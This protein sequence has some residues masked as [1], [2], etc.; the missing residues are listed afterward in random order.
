MMSP[1]I[2]EIP[3]SRRVPRSGLLLMVAALCM[4]CGPKAGGP[5]TTVDAYANA[6]ARQDYATAYGFMSATFRD[7]H[8][9][10]EFVR[11]MKENAAEANET[12]ARLRSPNREMNVTAEFRFGLGETMRLV[13]EGGA[14]RIAKNPIQ[15]YTQ[16][17]PRDALRSFLRAYRLRRWDVMLRFVPDEFRQH[18]D[19]DKLREQFEG[20]RQAELDA[21]MLRL[22]DSIDEPIQDNGNEARMSYGDSEVEFVRENGVWKIQD[23][24]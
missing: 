18:M 12:A 5:G 8:S 14:W 17:T 4:A 6:L 21:I 13:R 7:Q 9:K 15:F 11:M 1:P 24:D 10:E 23:L 22:E 3:T 16:S 2:T 20:E 19:E